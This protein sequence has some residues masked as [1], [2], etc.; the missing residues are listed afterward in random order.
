MSVTGDQAALTAVSG[1]AVLHV[2][3][4][5]GEEAKDL[6][7]DGNNFSSYNNDVMDLLKQNG[8][9]VTSSGKDRFQLIMTKASIQNL[10]LSQG[11]WEIELNGSN[12]L[13]GKG[14][15]LPDVASGLMTM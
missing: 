12:V 7:F 4:N 1:T 3:F 15:M 9:R 14:S 2:S 5:A 6:Y 8:I 11:T 10:Q 13:E